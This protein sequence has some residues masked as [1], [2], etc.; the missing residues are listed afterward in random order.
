MVA[1]VRQRVSNMAGVTNEEVR[2][3]ASSYRICPLGAHIG[4]QLSHVI[5][6][7]I[8]MSSIPL[9]DKWSLGFYLVCVT[10]SGDFEEQVR[11]RFISDHEVLLFSLKYFVEVFT[12]SLV[13]YPVSCI[14]SD[15]CH[16]CGNN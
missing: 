6:P 12:P 4:Q 5:S 13:N 3:V 2:I 7:E 16:F 14:H 10:F 9:F 11:C 8:R 15:V 1:E